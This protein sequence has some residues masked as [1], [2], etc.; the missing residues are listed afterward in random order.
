[1]SPY[2][3]KSLDKNGSDKPKVSPVGGA[4]GTGG[5]SNCQSGASVEK[6]SINLV[7]IPILGVLGGD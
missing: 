1:M 4:A 3:S 7:N 5:A 6:T 2:Q